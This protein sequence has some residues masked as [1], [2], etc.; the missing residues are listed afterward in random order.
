MTCI[1]KVTVNLK[2]KTVT[3]V[4]FVQDIDGPYLGLTGKSLKAIDRTG[5]FI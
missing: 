3:H 1:I 2:P 4:W 5:E